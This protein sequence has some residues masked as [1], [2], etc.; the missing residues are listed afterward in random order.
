M[1]LLIRTW[2]VFHGNAVPPE[3][4]AFLEEMVRL[5]VA[6]DP[7]VVCLQEVPAWALGRLG[8]W[9]GT[10][11]VGARTAA[12][13]L[14]PL[15]W[16]AELGRL[17]TEVNH[18]LFR[19]TFAG[20]GNAVLVAR[21]HAVRDARVLVLNARAFRR[22]QARWLGLDLVD[23]LAWAKERRV[24]QAVRIETDQ[25]SVLVAN[26]HTT[27]Y[28]ADE[29]VPDAELRRAAVFLEALGRPDEPL[30]LCGDVNVRADR[31]RT[32]HDLVAEGFSQP[33][34][35]IDQ[36]LVRGLAASEPVV[37]PEEQRR[38]DGRLLSD[39]APVEVV[40]G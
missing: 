3:R 37:W 33:A 1:S 26:L 10:S 23:R 18:G 29:R 20:Q 22:A 4:A 2:N 8:D 9:S 39:H 36:V 25:G 6:D 34:P 31:S 14:G 11:A 21:R 27:S 7:D 32:L 16:P 35:G 38:L 19:S 17:L 30:V 5:V 40:V 13:R 15:P 12:P 24:C 28:A